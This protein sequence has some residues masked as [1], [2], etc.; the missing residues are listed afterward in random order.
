MQSRTPPAAYKC[1]TYA[2]PRQTAHCEHTHTHTHACC[3][4]VSIS[5]WPNWMCSIWHTYPLCTTNTRYLSNMFCRQVSRQL[6]LQGHHAQNAHTHTHTVCICVHIRRTWNILFFYFSN[7]LKQ[8]TADVCVRGCCIT[9]AFGARECFFFSLDNKKL[10][11]YL[12][13]VSRCVYMQMWVFVRLCCGCLTKQCK[14]HQR[15]ISLCC[16]FI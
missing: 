15:H 9:Y 11:R 1:H 3:Q 13:A 2:N 12:R 6:T 5:R 14:K 8:I 16:W 7:R 4:N 10:T